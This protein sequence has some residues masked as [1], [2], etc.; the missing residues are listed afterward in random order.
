VVVG[1]VGSGRATEYTAMG[2]AVNVAARMEQTAE[3]ATV[4]ISGETYRLVEPMF[5]VESLGSID[6]KG[7]S[8][9]VPAYQVISLKEEPGRLRGVGGLS[10]PLIGREAELAHL[11][12][13]FAKVRAGRGQ[14]ICLIGEAGLGKSRLLE[15]ARAEWLQHSAPDTWEQSQA[16]PYESDRPYGLFQRFARDLFGIELNDSSEVIHHKVDSGLRGT[17]A[18]EEA[19]ALCSVALE[20]IIAAKVLH[21]APEFP[22]EVIKQDIY[23]I[24]YPAW[25]EHASRAPAVMV[26][27]DLQWS[28]QASADL[29]M[30]LLG[31]SEEVPVLFLLAFRPE[32][33]SPAWGVKVKAETDYPH[34]YSEI[35]LN[36]LEE[37][38][39]DRLVS[40][41]LRIAELPQEL[42]R[43]ILQKTEGNP[44]FVEE[45][46]R[47]LLEEDILQQTE[48]GLRWKPGTNLDEI[49]IPDTV[50]ALLMAR[51]DRLD[52]E[53]RGTLQLASVI[54][55]SFYHRVLRAI[56]D[57]TI[58]LDT[59]LST[60]E[61][62]DLV[63]EAAR[64]PELEYSFR[65]ELTRDA[66]YGSILRRRR[67]E[68]HQHVG[69]A[70]EA[71]FADSLEANAHRLAQHFA[72]AGDS[73]RAM[74][75]HVMSA[76]A[77]AAISANTDAAK[78][79]ARAIEA[80]ER[81]ELPAEE[82]AKLNDKYAVAAGM[83]RRA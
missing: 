8:Q 79:Y 47:S 70:M 12:D 65:H 46:V 14:V 60:L 80:A 54:G 19:V 11:R 40:A 13:A 43:L 49:V 45:V 39:T 22:A 51:M 82:L 83:N 17:G 69:E 59:H 23:E 25:S 38:H 7:R 61:R 34:R 73:E 48:E 9:P 58:A 35:T 24:V 6:V 30:H 56:S 27:D 5:E 36:R 62:V 21:E 44:Y 41:L 33:Q 66:A 37:E 77:A 55:R 50:Q 3:P 57:S 2:D 31:L 26:I 10:A 4:R 42:R 32:R 52:R 81:L 64:T 1:E 78:H 67:R 18:S 20:R 68:L 15:E 53:I 28:D 74:K 16:S 72:E 76:E 71:L 63:R 29:V 75:Y